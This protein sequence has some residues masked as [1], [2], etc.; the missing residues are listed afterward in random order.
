VS[1]P[2][3]VGSERRLQPHAQP[4]RWS[5]DPL[6]RRRCAVLV[7]FATHICPPCESALEELQRRGYEVRRVGGYAAIDQGRSQIV[8]EALA[9]GESK[10]GRS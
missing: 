8:T 6:D 1:D 7:P 2:P 10:R 9:D 3:Q 5:D 4:R